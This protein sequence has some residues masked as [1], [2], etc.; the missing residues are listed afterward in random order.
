[1]SQ[2]QAC[3]EVLVVDDDR[4]I[5][6]AMGE[7]LV[8]EGYVVGHAGNGQ[9]AIEYLRQRP[10][11]P[12]LILLDLNMPVM[13]GW[14]FRRIQQQDPQLAKIPV[15]VFSADRSLSRGTATLDAAAYL[16]KPLDIDLLLDTVSSLCHPR[17]PSAELK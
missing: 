9:E 1:M 15:V 2:T 3:T 17:D 5:R 10:A 6:E 11:V 4:S 12:C 8:D 16:E 13:T 14:E 7:L